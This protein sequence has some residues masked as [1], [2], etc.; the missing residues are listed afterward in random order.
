MFPKSIN[1]FTFLIFQEELRN[2]QLEL[3]EAPNTT[4]ESRDEIV[5]ED[6]QHDPPVRNQGNDKCQKMN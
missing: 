2:K 5:E 6:R 4:P 1:I 3:D